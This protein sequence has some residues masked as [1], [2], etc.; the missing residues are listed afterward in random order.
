MQGRLFILAG[1]LLG[2]A[3]GVTAETAQVYV[4]TCVD[5]AGVV[6]DLAQVAVDT[7]RPY[8]T[9]PAPVQAGF[10]FTHWTLSTSQS[11]APRDAWGRATDAAT[12]VPYE[13][14]T[15]TAH[16][17]SNLT[18]DDQD[19]MPDGHELYWYGDLST[20]TPASDTDGDGYSFAQEIQYGLNPLFAD[21]H[22]SGVWHGD[23]DLLQY[24][25]D[26]QPLLVIRCE[27]EGEFFKTI[28][29]YLRPGT[30]VDT[31]AAYPADP[32]GKLPAS[33]IQKTT[34]AH[35]SLNGQRQADAW[36]RAQDRLTFKM[37]SHDVE[38]VAVTERKSVK[39][40]LLYWYGDPAQPLDSD[41]DG[42]GFTLRDELRAGTNP[43]FAD[44][45]FTSWRGVVHADSDVVQYNADR[46]AM[47]TIRSQPE[48]ELFATT[49][50]YVKPGKLVQTAT[51]SVDTTTFA[52]WTF[53]GQ[54]MTDAWGRSVDRAKFA[55]PAYDV[56]LVAV[57][58][59]DE[60]KKKYLYWTGSA[61]P[62]LAADV[63]QDGYT[64]AQ[65][66]QQG[67]SP[68]FPNQTLSYAGVV[69]ADTDRK[70]MNLQVYEDVS[71]IL[72]G[73]HYE[74]FFASLLGG[75]DGVRH[76]THATP[77]VVDWNRDGKLD[78]LVAR[79]G[80]VQ[81]YLNTG[82]NANPD[83]T[84]AT[85]TLPAAFTAKFAAVARPALAASSTHI[86][87]SD[88]GGTIAAWDR[89]AGTWSD[90]ELAGRPGVFDRSDWARQQAA[91]GV[92]LLHRWSFNG[93]ATGGGTDLEIG[94][95]RVES[96]SVGGQSARLQGAVTASGTEVTLA[97]GQRGNSY[98]D[99]GPN[100]LP[101]DGSPATIEIWA[102]QRSAQ[103][104]SR[105]IDIGN[106]TSDGF[107]IAW[108]NGT[109]VNQPV[110][111]LNPYPGTNA[112]GLGA[113]ALNVETYTS[114]A[115]EPQPE[116]NWKIT[117][118][119]RDART[120]AVLGTVSFLSG[121]T[122]G[123][124]WSLAKLGQ[125]NCW[126]GHSQYGSDRDANASYNE[127]RVWNRALT[128]GECAAH[129][130]AGPDQGL[131]AE[132]PETPQDE[133][134]VALGA[135]GSLTLADGS[136]LAVDERMVDGAASLS[137]GDADGDGLTDI[138]AGDAAGRIW[139]YKR[140][141]EAAFTLQHKVWGG[142]YEGFAADLAVA[143]TDWDDDGDLDA[144]AGT[145]DGRLILLRDPAGG[146]PG[147]VSLAA[148]VDSVSLKWDPNAQS[149]IR[150]YYVYRS[151]K[152]AG[153]WTRL[154]PE[155]SPVPRYVD[156]PEEIRAYDYAVSSVTRLYRTGNSRPVTS[157]SAKTAP[158]SAA[159]GH[160]GFTWRPAAGFDG[161]DVAV[162]L[163]VE[164]ARHLAAD[165]FQ[166]KVAFDPAVLVPSGLVKSGLT[167]K[168][169]VVETRGAGTWLVAGAGGEI[170]DGEGAFLT[171]AFAVAD[172][173][174][175]AD[176]SVTIEEFELK[177]TG[178]ANVVPELARKAGGVE[179]GGDSPDPSDPAVVVPGSLGD[180]DG[181]G[182]LGWNDVE[183][184]LRW[185]DRPQAEI[186]EGVRRAGDFTGDGVLDGRDYLLL[187]RFFREREENGGRMSGWDDNHNA[188]REG[189]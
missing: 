150:G 184:Y 172:G 170:Q 43:L 100:I 117:A 83:L 13:N 98:I 23:G 105:V 26:G 187:K 15:A 174:R 78:L 38:L 44:A 143:A 87:L 159:L 47:L 126:L 69:H 31:Y 54:R 14:T 17:V 19:G 39:R 79:A 62:D 182:R 135:D 124:A 72:V 82:S 131:L 111:T 96:D 71:G 136:S 64:L 60:Q 175:L 115:F 128:D 121:T 75:S 178:H 73:G 156:R 104:W 180:L 129:V 90:T 106:A 164:N 186:P 56:E 185:K 76:G 21:A 166:L 30:A 9:A 27:P 52:Y 24:N 153:A 51:Q 35:W 7:A 81:L 154:N 119:N 132:Q 59:R 109:N 41:T 65:E 36:G 123:V 148:G 110:M 183:L 20:A 28:R 48:G 118:R 33:E 108:S 151:A 149:R 11:F 165:G 141:G 158:L 46:A 10:I 137:F 171:F 140:T 179:L 1:L 134:L 138:L 102:T 116:G 176:T 12:F 42:D 84:E 92:G 53:N 144:L 77:A 22:D 63:D 130:Q 58:E 97:G 103:S 66:L 89:A 112:S 188:Y 29:R 133:V 34:F 167:E 93:T 152:G 16:Y 25:P 107:L 6:E 142:T 4:R 85:D 163:S 55:M 146:R 139:F 50:E 67:T 37:P 2:V 40:Q 189:K 169:E 95:D 68:Y 57:T 80:G 122:G 161:D 3:G 8:T 162:V 173:S 5:R 86:Y 157:E 101:A 70:E 120:G 160:V 32:E 147:N 74:P 99:L 177:S 88:R 61:T 18:D 113:Y 125:A 127:V 155:T 45:V 181:N 94:A 145:A 168:L 49:Q 91:G 114:V